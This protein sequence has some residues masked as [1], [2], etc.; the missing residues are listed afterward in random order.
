MVVEGESRAEYNE[1]RVQL[2]HYTEAMMQ[3][4]LYC[5]SIFCQLEC[6]TS[7]GAWPNWLIT[8]IINITPVASWA[9]SLDLCVVVGT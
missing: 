7:T 6:A 2:I 1:S 4:H 9:L 3:V 5:S 8:N